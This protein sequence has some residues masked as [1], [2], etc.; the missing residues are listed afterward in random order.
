MAP[1]NPAVCGAPAGP[2]IDR[3]NH[4]HEPVPCTLAADATT[5]AD[6]M[7]A[8]REQGATLRRIEEA[9]KQLARGLAPSVAPGRSGS[10]PASTAADPMGAGFTAGSTA[11]DPMGAGFMLTQR[12]LAE[13]LALPASYVSA[14]V[15][16]FKLDEDAHYALTVRSGAKR[17]VNYHP[18]AIDRF[19]ELVHGPPAFLD[20]RA[21]RTLE[22]VRSRLRE[23]AR[24]A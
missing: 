20:Q 8:L 10:A 12:A 2:A 11:A 7:A 9:L 1:L 6:V 21:R 16:A 18:R 15:R 23:P 14:L 3:P 17:L 5:S 13:A 22:Q 19:R 4:P 24:A